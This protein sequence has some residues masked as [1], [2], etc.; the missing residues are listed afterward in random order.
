MQKEQNPYQIFNNYCLRTPSFPFVFYKKLTENSE[1]SKEKLKTVFENPLFK[2]AIYLASPE[3]YVQLN[4]WALGKLTDLKKVERL[5]TA[6]LKYATRIST[7]CTPFGLFSTCILG[8]FAKETA[9]QLPEN[10]AYQKTT[11]FDMLFLST[12]FDEIS[13]ETALKKQLLFYPNTSIYTIGN[14]YRYTEYILTNNKRSYTLEAIEVSEYL[15]KILNTATQGT[16]IKNLAL[17]IVDTDVLIEDAIPFIEALI[18]NQFLVTELAPTITGKD[19]LAA[20]INMLSKYKNTAKTIAELNVYQNSLQQIDTGSKNHR[21]TFKNIAKTTPI[22]NEKFLFQTDFY[23]SPKNNTISK[24]HLKTVKK[25]MYLLNKMTTKYEN[26]NL[27]SFKNS[28]TKRFE[29]RSIPLLFA[30]DSET[31]IGYAQKRNDHHPFIDD[32]MVSFDKKTTETIAT[33]S[34]DTILQEKLFEALKNRQTTIVLTDV[35]FNTLEENW[36]DLPDTMSSMIE[37]IEED[38]VT[39]IYMKSVDGASGANLLARFSHGNKAIKAHVQDIIDIE[40]TIQKDKIIAEIVHLPQAR[41]GN[42]LQRANTRRYEIPYLGQSSLPKQQQIALN[43]IRISIK[44]N[45]IVLWSMS[46]QK[47]IIPRL[48][49]AHNYSHDALP[50]YHFLCDLQSQNLRNS[51]YFNWNA[52]LKKAPFLPRVTYQNILF[53]KARW[54]IQTKNVAHLISLNND[55]LLTEINIWRAQIQLPQYV[56]LV[57][58]DHTLVINMHNSTTFKMLLQTIKQKQTFVLEEF[59]FD[60]DGIVKQ[61][62]DYFCNQVVVSFFNAKKLAN[63]KQ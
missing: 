29:E 45:R 24:S 55:T 6:L 44:N 63:S 42:I 5:Q 2:E 61:K 21:Q 12:L 38:G 19:S 23:A 43:D 10:G 57:E 33:T 32:L 37:F 25:G 56:Q 4:K 62:D 3:L 47:E 48:T 11:R 30:L 17:S 53:S 34:F 39:K 54:H 50:I 20:V 9:I 58:S 31:G 7:R 41:T 60:T 16:T 36:S 1:I 51:L 27:I 22:I 49:N 13:N 46:L 15:E 8:H 35:D 26:S 14:Q 52:S 40:T 28:F 18:D 59:L